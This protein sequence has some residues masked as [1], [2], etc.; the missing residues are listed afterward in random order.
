M[1]LIPK[2]PPRPKDSHKGT[3]GHLLLIGGSSRK[4]G[5]ILLSGR[6][7]MRSGVGLAT[8]ALPEKALRKFTSAFRDGLELMYEPMPATAQGTFSRKSS[9]SLLKILKK[10][11]ALALG[12]GLGVNADTKT[13]VKNILRSTELPLVLDADGLNAIAPVTSLYQKFLKNRAVL[14]PHVGEI[15][16]LLKVSVEYIQKNRRECALELAKK[17]G[18]I[19]VLKGHRTVVASPEGKV[20]INPTGNPGMATAGMGDVLT[21]IIGALLAQGSKPFEAAIVGVFIHGRAGDLMARRIGQR[22]LI[23]SDVIAEIPKAFLSTKK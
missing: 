5:S 2:L 4:P 10:K 17:T 3:F 23:A 13:F 18:A 7:A 9:R 15:A 8:V 21:G 1:T 6:A 20:F 14:T 16:R 11:T 12:P 19:A 22:G